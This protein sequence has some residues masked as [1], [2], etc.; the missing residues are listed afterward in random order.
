MH[1]F[2]RNNWIKQEQMR[3]PTTT[4]KSYAPELRL[5]RGRVMAAHVGRQ[6]RGFDFDMAAASRASSIERRA[7][8]L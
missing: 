2:V 4:M 7:I 1:T 6:E 5:R 3:S 8:E